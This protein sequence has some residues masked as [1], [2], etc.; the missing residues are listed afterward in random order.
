MSKKEL[1][2][3]INSLDGGG[4]ERVMTTLVNELVNTHPCCLIIIEN[5]IKYELD[6]RVRVVV[7]S[8]AKEGNSLKKLFM[9]PILTY[10]LSMLIKSN[11]FT[12]IMSFLH[13]SNYINILSSSFVSHKVIISERTTPSAMYNEN[14]VLSFINKFLT[15]FLYP[16]ADQIIS[17]SYGIHDD[18]KNNFNIS[19]QQNVIYNPCNIEKIEQLAT[20][21]INLDLERKKTIITVGSLE[22]V[23]NQAILIEAFSKL[24]S[25]YRLIILGEGSL[26]KNLRNQ[27]KSLGLYERVIFVG[28]DNNPYKYFKKS[29]IFVL[30]S[31][32][33]GFPNVLVEAMICGCSVISTDCLSGPR[34]I[35]APNTDISIRLKDKIEVAEYGMLV[36]V[37]DTDKLYEA[38]T[39]LITNEALQNELVS[40]ASSRIA[41][42]DIKLISQKYENVICNSKKK[43]INVLALTKYSYSGP[44]SRYRFYNYENSFKENSI[45]LDL[46]PLFD[47]QY[48]N[49]SNKF[50]KMFIVLFSYFKR[51]SILLS[52]L[53]LKNKYT[54]VLVEYELFPYMPAIFETLLSK[55]GIKYIVDYDDAIFHKYDMNNNKIIRMLLKHKIANVVRHAKHVI[56]CNEYLKSYV[57]EYNSNIL[58]LPTVVILNN[59][60]EKIKQFIKEDTNEFIIGWIGSR[61]T[62]I[63]ILEIL[64]AIKQFINKYRNI[65]F[66]LVGFD[67]SLLSKE[68]I[69][70]HN[71]NIIRWSEEEEINNILHFDIGIMP[72]HDD[73]WSRGKCGFKLVQYMS[74]KKP[75]IAS[76]VG[77]NCTL[78]QNNING[79]LVKDNDEWFTAFETLYL[80]KKLRF[81]MSKNNFEK[82]ER[83]FNYDKNASQYIKLIKNMDK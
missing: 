56:I 39:Y 37:K 67:E 64:P 42:L 49:V 26:E 55:R 19:N 53:I 22:K 12:Q 73:P 68:E 29:S 76:P 35:L 74:C 54:L 40:K 59:Y 3:L 47:K 6:D 81:D 24:S 72:L 83:E 63:Y 52:V 13:R 1:V 4:A 9:I 8:D 20:K 18:L 25:E 80:D 50:I 34:E 46:K 23:K 7:L 27:V 65:R 16:K 77:I 33:E 78:V 43:V 79:F 57:E 11:R 30:S 44:S 36:P 71:I 31:N 45:S 38:L 75:V 15:S 5:K 62:S 66:D 14:T 17:A 82:I 60:K 69:L 10:K 28:F 2:F 41:E 32:S 58:K 70:N 61:T 48:F 21:D 51:L